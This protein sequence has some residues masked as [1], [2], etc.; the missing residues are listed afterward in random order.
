[1]VS[2]FG[3]GGST[4]STMGFGGTGGVTTGLGFGLGLGTTGL[5]VGFGVLICFKLS[6]IFFSCFLAGK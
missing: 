2:G 6:D 4:F 1:M 3:F 5:G